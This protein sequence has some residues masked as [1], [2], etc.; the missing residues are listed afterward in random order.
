[1]NASLWRPPRPPCEP[2]SSERLA[3]A[4]AEAAV[5]ADQLLERHDLVGRRVVEA[6]RDDVAGVLK[7]GDPVQPL[8]RR[9]P[10]GG[11]RIVPDAPAFIEEVRAACPNRHDPLL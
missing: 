10:I 5:R 1:M 11:E 3:L 2:T 8:R 9:G 4:A 6:D 7:P